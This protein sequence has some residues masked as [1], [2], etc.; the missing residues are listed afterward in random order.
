M[1]EIV[2]S[3]KYDSEDPSTRKREVTA[4]IKAGKDL[5]CNPRFLTISE[6]SQKNLTSPPGIC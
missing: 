1:R 2:L 3:H 5:M 6:I 4:L